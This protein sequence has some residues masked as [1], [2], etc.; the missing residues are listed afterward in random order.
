MSSSDRISLPDFL[1]Q[2]ASNKIPHSKA[3]HV[4]SKMSVPALLITDHLGMELIHG[5]DTRPIKH[6]SHWQD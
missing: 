3:I 6:Q 5:E 4:A 1:K 2:L